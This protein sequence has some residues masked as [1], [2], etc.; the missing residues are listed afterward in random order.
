M[1]II[2]STAAPGFTLDYPAA[3]SG[4]ATFTAPTD[5]VAYSGSEQPRIDINA[6]VVFV[7]HGIVA[8]EYQVER[9]RRRRREGQSGDGDGQ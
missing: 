3:V 4:R 2:E 7:G 9:L 6:P 1:P 5:F 8:P